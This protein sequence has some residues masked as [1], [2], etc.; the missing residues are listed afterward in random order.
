MT[1]TPPA[2]STVGV[3]LSVR[4]NVTFRN[5]KYS[6]GTDAVVDGDDVSGNAKFSEMKSDAIESMKE[7]D[8]SQL[9]KRK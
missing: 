6:M 7:G 3:S 8:E 4:W 1:G 9:E 2:N 5:P